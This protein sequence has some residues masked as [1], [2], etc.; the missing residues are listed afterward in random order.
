MRFNI[1]IVLMAIA[2]ISLPAAAQQGPAGIPGVFSLVES[3]LPA[4]EPAQN[5]KKK[6][7]D[8]DCSKAKNV[9]QCKEQQDA[10][11]NILAACKGKTGTARTQCLKQQTRYENCKKSADPAGCL[12]FEKTY[13]LCQK[14]LG[15]AHRQCLFDN[16]ISK[17]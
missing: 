9:E 12:R 16:L 10:R 3:V 11:K 7:S 14:K 13:D 4:P 2:M 1:F 8:G 17:P 15:Q 6:S 5:L